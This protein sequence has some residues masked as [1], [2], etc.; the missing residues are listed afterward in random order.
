MTDPKKI[1]RT[2]RILALSA[3]VI[4]ILCAILTLVFAF[5]KFFTGSAFYASAWKASAWSMFVIPLV[6]Y[7]MILIHN[8][9]TKNEKEGKN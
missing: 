7:G 9:V 8:I 5:L 3:V 1:E 2:R 6:L 4:M